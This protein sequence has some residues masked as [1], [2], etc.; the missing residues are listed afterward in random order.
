[1]IF[2]NISETRGEDNKKVHLTLCTFRGTESKMPS[3]ELQNIEII[4]AHSVQKQNQN[5]THMTFLNQN[6]TRG[7]LL[8]RSD[9]INLIST[10][11]EL[12]YK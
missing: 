8:I 3:E 5:E 11:K 6:I 9:P 7:V 1:M 4:R 12:K 10:A 2:Q